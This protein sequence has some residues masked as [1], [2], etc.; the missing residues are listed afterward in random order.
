M[1][2]ANGINFLEFSE[3]L[4]G[5]NHP[6]LTDTV[7][8]AL[9]QIVAKF[10]SGAD[11]QVTR[12]VIKIPSATDIEVSVNDDDLVYYNTST[13]KYEKAIDSNILGFIDKTN[14]MVHTF[15]MYQ[16][17]TINS[18][19]SGSKYYL[20]SGTPGGLTT[21]SSS[22]IYVGIAFGTNKILNSTIGNITIPSILFNVDYT[23]TI[24]ITT[25]ADYTLTEQQNSKR[26]YV[27]T[28]TGVVLTAPRNI[29]VGNTQRFFYVKNSTAQDLTFKTLAG[30]GITTSPNTELKL[31]C[32]GTNVIEL[33]G[34][35][36]Y[37]QTVQNLTITS[38]V[39]YPASDKPRELSIYCKSPAGTA[40]NVTITMGGVSKVLGVANQP[41][42]INGL[43]IG[44]TIIPAGLTFT[45]T[46]TNVTTRT[47][48]ITQ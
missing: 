8:R 47:T 20:D 19:V 11:T 33:L 6:T 41:A 15:G 27:I 1:S 37:G 9:K 13:S 2:L 29:I 12:N 46:D 43:Y 23:E 10:D 39:T 45:I 5:Q 7:N 42:G 31:Y 44:S 48:H 16:L 18:L 34:G 36:G 22:G 21:D 32:D 38:G 26:R 35:I 4:V 30:T 17:L 3:F 40:S 25:D 14:L 24:N 28:D